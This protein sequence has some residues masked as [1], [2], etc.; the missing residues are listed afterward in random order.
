MYDKA[1]INGKVYIDGSFRKT[2]LYIKDGKFEVITPQ[3]FPAIE[4]IDVNDL[5]ILPGLIDPHVHFDLDL[6]EFTSADDFKNGSIT[7]AYGGITTYIDFL[8]P[9]FK[10]SEFESSFKN[11]SIAA[12][13]SVID[14]AFHAT[15]G[16]YDDAVK[17]LIEQCIDSGISSIKV[18]TT[19]SESNRRCSSSI[20][21][22]LLET[23]LTVLSHSEDDSLVDSS[24]ETISDFESSRPV[25]SE[26]N[27]VETL[28]GLVEKTNGKLYI[29]HTSSGST[30]E[31]IKEDYPLLINKHLFM[32]SCPQYFY[33]SKDL[34]ERENGC[35]YLLAPPLRSKEEQAKLIEHFSSVFSIGTDHCPFTIAEKETY[36]DAYKVPKGL[37]SIEYSFL[38]MRNLFGDIVIDKM[39]LNPARIFN[40]SAKGSIALGKDADLFI[41]DPLQTTRVT[42]GHSKC[43]YSA[44]EGIELDG[45]IIST[46]SNGEFVIRNRELIH[47]K[48]RYVR[49]ELDESHHQCKDLRL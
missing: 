13:D 45:Q 14:Y 3:I 23:D 18:F 32:E 10:S 49:R 34:F 15:L 35:H 12:K 46:L 47:H 11:R 33:L 48:G 4:T 2:N 6:G 31:M 8:D 24:W 41:I 9:V 40:L 39:S 38:L 42:S 1:L 21:E 29:V 25:Q 7:A 17:P 36:R 43:D 27:A 19:Y 26:L 44:Y 30:L 16:N 5:E 22:E 20:I 37:G 28:A